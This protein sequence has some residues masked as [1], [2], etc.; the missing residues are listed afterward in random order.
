MC[1]LEWEVERV[2]IFQ[3]LG[4][5]GSV[6]IPVLRYGAPSQITSYL[7]ILGVLM[8]YT[9][10]IFLNSEVVFVSVYL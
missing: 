6:Y 7:D 10:D 5:V 9:S 1:K 3:V 4:N 8:R 2:V